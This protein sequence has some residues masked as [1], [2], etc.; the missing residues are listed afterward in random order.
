MVLS[1]AI[2][3]PRFMLD[4]S[5]RESD[6]HPAEPMENLRYREGLLAAEAVAEETKEW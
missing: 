4:I 1:S 5:A 2:P 3:L 6:R